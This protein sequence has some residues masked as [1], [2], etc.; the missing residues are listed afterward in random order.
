LRLN[1]KQS[2]LK[3]PVFVFF[4]VLLT[5]ITLMLLTSRDFS[6]HH[7]GFFHATTDGVV[8]ETRVVKDLVRSNRKSSGL[9]TDHFDPIV[10]FR[11]R[12]NEKEYVATTPKMLGFASVSENQAKWIVSRYTPGQKVHVFYIASEPQRALLDVS[13]PWSIIV[14]GCVAGF[15]LAILIT[16]AKLFR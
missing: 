5:S 11:Y 7:L 3:N 14:S 9:Y 4:A 8:L 2:A 15:A 13:F 16:V 6:D 10:V 1:A 12:V